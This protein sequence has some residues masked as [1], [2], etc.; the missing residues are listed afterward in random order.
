MPYAIATVNLSAIDLLPAIDLAI[1][2]AEPTL[3]QLSGKSGNLMKVIRMI[4]S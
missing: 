2:A 4:T 1:H 3:R